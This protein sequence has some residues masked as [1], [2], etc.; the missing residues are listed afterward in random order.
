MAKFESE[1]ELGQKLWRISSLLEP[2]GECE[3]C[4]QEIFKRK[5]IVDELEFEIIGVSVLKSFSDDSVATQYTLFR[6][7]EAF[8][9]VVG[10]NIG[11][12]YFTSPILARAEC[13]RRNK[14]D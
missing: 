8:F 3:C 7:S 4:A 5:W 10:A 14:D 9:E 11:K 2:L 13:D 1:L 12:T 6:S